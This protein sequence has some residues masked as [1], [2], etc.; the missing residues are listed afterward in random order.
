MPLIAALIVAALIAL[1]VACT[2]DDSGPADHDDPAHEE[3]TDLIVV[4]SL[5][6]GVPLLEG[7]SE[8]ILSFEHVVR[9]EKYVRLRMETFDV[10]G[11]EVGAPMRIMTGQ[12]DVHLMEAELTA[13]RE[14]GGE[15]DN[16]N[17]VLM[18]ELYA[19]S[20]GL[21][22]GDTF[23]LDGTAYE[24]VVAGEFSTAPA[25]LSRSILL[26]LSLAQEIYG[27]DGKVTHFW[28]TVDSPESTHDVIQAL[29]IELGDSVDVL[30]RTYQR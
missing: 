16:K 18:G 8:E 29:Q 3:G 17:F 27:I 2:G 9:V 12:P 21:T 20:L 15:D 1:F 14:L 26:P 23:A 13:G 6:K 7:L 28:V 11:V 22:T 19:D 4:K 30:P 25:S 10:V 5:E 24:L